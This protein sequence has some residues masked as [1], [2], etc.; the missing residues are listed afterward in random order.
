MPEAPS[1]SG[2]FAIW[3]DA[4]AMAILAGS[5]RHRLLHAIELVIVKKH[6]YRF[7]ARVA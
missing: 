4:V 2:R 1:A 7:Y 3:P 6:A 5:H